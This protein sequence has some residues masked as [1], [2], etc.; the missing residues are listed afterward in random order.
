[1]KSTVTVQEVQKILPIA[2][3]SVNS[4]FSISM[5]VYENILFSF[6]SLQEMLKYLNQTSWY[7]IIDITKEIRATL[8]LFKICFSFWVQ[9]HSNF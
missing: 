9:T 7:K 8:R 3:R 5:G 4:V 6:S 1:M 2:R